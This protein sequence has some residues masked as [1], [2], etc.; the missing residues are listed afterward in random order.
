[1][2]LREIHSPLTL[3]VW[4]ASGKLTV[5]DATVVVLHCVDSTN[6]KRWME[7]LPK[8][9]RDLLLVEIVPM[10]ARTGN[11]T[12]TVGRGGVGLEENPEAVPA[13]RE[14]YYTAP[15]SF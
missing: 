12:F 5:W 11:E 9:L 4:W 10:F 13:L 1:M 2:N 7:D 3:T 8:D 15:P 14:W 6:A